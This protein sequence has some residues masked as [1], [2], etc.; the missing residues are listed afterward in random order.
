MKSWKILVVFAAAA[1]VLLWKAAPIAAFN[2]QPEPPGRYMVSMLPGQDGLSLSLLYEP[3]VRIGAS[4]TCQGVVKFLNLETGQQAAD[5]M[6]FS[7]SIGKGQVRRF[8]PRPTDA[9][10]VMGV[11]PMPWRIEVS[12]SPQGCAIVSAELYD[13]TSGRTRAVIRY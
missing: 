9:I 7:M 11:D 13:V 3:V 10:G 4:P 2:P 5:S 8:E 12:A 6:P 1:A